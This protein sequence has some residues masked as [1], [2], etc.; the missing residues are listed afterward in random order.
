[1]GFEDL[2][3]YIRKNTALRITTCKETSKKKLPNR[4]YN[5]NILDFSNY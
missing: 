2:E 3:M 1:M 5:K 4:N